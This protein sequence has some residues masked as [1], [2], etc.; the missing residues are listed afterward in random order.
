MYS[1]PLKAWLDPVS[2]PELSKQILQRECDEVSL[3]GNPHWIYFEDS[4]CRGN[5]SVPCLCSRKKVILWKRKKG[6]TSFSFL[7][8]KKPVP[9]IAT[10]KTALSIEWKA[11]LQVWTC[12]KCINSKC[13]F[14]SY[15]LSVNV[16]G[17][18]KFRKFYRFFKRSG[19]MAWIL[20][21]VFGIGYWWGAE[22][23]MKHIFT[24][25]EVYHFKIEQISIHYVSNTHWC[26]QTRR[27]RQQCPVPEDITWPAAAPLEPTD[28]WLQDSSHPPAEEMR[29]EEPIT[30]KICHRDQEYYCQLVTMREIV[31]VCS[32]GGCRT[33]VTDQKLTCQIKLSLNVLPGSE[34]S[35]SIGPITGLL[36]SILQH[37]SVH[38][39]C[40][41]VVLC[42]FRFWMQL[43]AQH[44]RGADLRNFTVFTSHY[45]SHS[46][47]IFVMTGNHI[48]FVGVTVVQWLATSRLSGK[49]VGLN[50]M[51][52]QGLSVWSS[53][54]VAVP[55]CLLFFPRRPDFHSSMTCRWG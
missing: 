48:S 17:K 12:A 18:K 16:N 1:H 10:E 53:H 35:D 13:V 19:E 46:R 44:N 55:T 9:A 15:S 8:V 42:Y 32:G 37:P 25:P 43:H 31:A 20:V 50:L 30:W 52:D 4:S 40:W 49:V 7:G 5:V 26:Q 39:P 38:E 47:Q 51:A 14:F 23:K 27:Q 29:G 54:A 41:S 28:M 6:K 22:K 36:A 33:V 45:L 2:C 34:G 3:P 21:L 11:N 24:G